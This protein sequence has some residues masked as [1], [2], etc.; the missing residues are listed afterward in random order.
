LQD[1]Y[2]VLL[3]HQNQLQNLRFI[4]KY[5]LAALAVYATADLL[6]GIYVSSFWKAI[7]VALVLGLM[8]ITIKPVMIL[9]TIPF[10]LLT[11]GIFLLVINAAVIM[12][13]GWIIDGFTVNGFWWALLFSI[14]QSIIASLLEKLVLPER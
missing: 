6:P 4:I 14:I 3:L 12:L 10:T 9:L 11:F 13:A 2:N 7:L 5:L 1:Y 8:N